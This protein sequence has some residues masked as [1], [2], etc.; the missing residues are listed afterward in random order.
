[1][2]RVVTRI[3][4]V[5]AVLVIGPFAGGPNR[6]VLAQ[7]ATPASAATTA[8]WPMF[9]GNPARTGSMPGMGP[10]GSPTEQWRFQAAGGIASTPAIANG[11]VYVGCDCDTLYALD[12]MTGE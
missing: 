7:E 9:R 1:M 10:Q 8:D 3:M 2:L 12:A 11:V 5:A 6:A 4:I